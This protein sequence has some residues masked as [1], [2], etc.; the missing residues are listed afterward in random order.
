MLILKKDELS[1]HDVF[2]FMQGQLNKTHWLESSIYL[3]EEVIGKTGFVEVLANNL[4]NFNYFGPTEVGKTD[5]G[6]IKRIVLSSDSVQMK[7]LLT[8]IDEWANVCFKKYPCF[9]ICGL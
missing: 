3:T 2:E 5:W 6:N 1:G 4:V 9:T 8:E 7:Q